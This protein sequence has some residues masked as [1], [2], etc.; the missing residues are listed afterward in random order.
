M[1][2][3]TPSFASIQSEDDITAWIAK[4]DSTLVILDCHISWSGPCESLTPFFEG[5]GKQHDIEACSSRLAVVTMEMPKYTE[6]FHN[7]LDCVNTS[8]DTS[9]LVEFFDATSTGSCRPLFAFLSGGKVISFVENTNT[10]ELERLI[11]KNI[12]TLSEAGFDEKEPDNVQ[13]VLDE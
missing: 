13:H 11:L 9:P 12:P 5:I 8:K 2:S 3:F 4:S 1:N 6:V 10:P 7:L